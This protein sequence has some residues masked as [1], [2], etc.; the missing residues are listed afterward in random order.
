MAHGQELNRLVNVSSGLKFIRSKS[1]D[2]F[3]S[4][5]KFVWLHQRQVRNHEYLLQIV[6]INFAKIT[7]KDIA[8]I[9]AIYICHM[10]TSV[11]A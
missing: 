2:N 11:I 1:C 3:S 8:T 9:V 4:K 7:L 6:T 5:S 10:A